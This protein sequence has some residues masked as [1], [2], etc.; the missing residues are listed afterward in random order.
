MLLFISLPLCWRKRQPGIQI[1][2][3]LLFISGAIWRLALK[4]DSNTSHVIVYRESADPDQRVSLIQIHLMLL[5]IN[6][7]RRSVRQTQS[8]KYISCYCLS[9]CRMVFRQKARIQI[10][11]MLLFILERRAE[12][13]G[14]LVFKYI[15]CYCL[16][17]A[18][19]IW[20]LLV[21]FKY[22]SCYCLSEPGVAPSL[23]VLVFK[24]ISCY[25]LSTARAF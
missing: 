20:C 5:F 17:M 24:Y 4:T 9:I 6:I 2:L 18:K 1:H 7:P 3:M 13:A 11:L 8:F 23:W 10:H 14:I 12:E 21:Q 16:S 22:I 25:C 19:R 15:S